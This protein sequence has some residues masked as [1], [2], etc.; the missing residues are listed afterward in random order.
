[1]LGSLIDDKKKLGAASSTS[2]NSPTWP[3]V[4]LCM[5]SFGAAAAWTR[6]RT[7]ALRLSIVKQGD[8]MVVTNVGDSRVV[9]DTVFDDDVIT[10][11]S[12]S[13]T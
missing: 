8:L 13:S 10:S 6:C 1:M 7:A 3:H 12:S 4:P 2:R 5:T 11:S 9:L